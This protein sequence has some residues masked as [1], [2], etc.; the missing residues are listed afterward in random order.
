MK[1]ENEYFVVLRRAS[2]EC[3]S[4]SKEMVER[5]SIYDRAEALAG[6]WIAEDGNRIWVV[7]NQEERMYTFVW[8][9][10]DMDKAIDFYE[11][12]KKNELG[13][14]VEEV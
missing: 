12:L 5:I 7:P 4:K 6:N 2:S 11:V 13:I 14:R 9:F 1:K 3:T 10:P 8:G